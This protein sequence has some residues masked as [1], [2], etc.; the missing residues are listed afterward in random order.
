MIVLLDPLPKHQKLTLDIRRSETGPGYDATMQV[1][2][3][4][5]GKLVKE[6]TITGEDSISRALS[7][8]VAKM[9]WV[10]VNKE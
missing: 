7:A 6:A 5:T 1:K 9:N 4:K 8:V 10:Q 3:Q 2:T